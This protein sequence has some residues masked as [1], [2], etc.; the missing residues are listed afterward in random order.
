MAA[1]RPSIKQL[2]SK[3]LL[4]IA[5]LGYFA[6]SRSSACCVPERRRSRSAFCSGESRA[7][8]SCADSQVLPP[9]AWYV[10]HSSAVKRMPRIVRGSVLRGRPA[11][12]GLVVVMLRR[13]GY[14]WPLGAA[15]R[16]DSARS[17]GAVEAY[18]RPRMLSEDR[19]PRVARGCGCLAGSRPRQQHQRCMRRRSVRRAPS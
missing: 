11:R 12:R 3:F 2:P 6:G 1:C 17:T 16:T 7:R 13:P 19:T 18:C 10:D 9:R 4:G 5:F 8:A 15:E 14:G